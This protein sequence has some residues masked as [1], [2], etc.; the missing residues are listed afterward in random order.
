MSLNPSAAAVTALREMG[1][2][3]VLLT[4]DNQRA[5]RRVAAL[6]GIAPQDTFAGT[7]PEEKVTVLRDLRASAGPVAF[8]GDGVN[9]AAALAQA[10]L[11]LAIGT[12]TDAAIRA[13]D[14]DHPVT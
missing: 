1:L 8:V 13:A 10:D 2:R 5:A 7:R 4:G 9:D 3:S 12:G 6:M 11:G 14:P